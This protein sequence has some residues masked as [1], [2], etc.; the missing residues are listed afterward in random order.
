[1]SNV[2]TYTYGA[3]STGNPQLAN[4]LLTITSPNAQPGGPDAGNDTVNVYD[5]SGRV[6]SQTDP[7]GFQTTF[8][9][10]VNAA[11]GDCMNPATGTGFVTVS[12]PDGNTTVYSYQQGTL[13]AT[14]KFTGTTLTSRDRS[15]SPTRPAGTLLDTTSTDGNGNTTTDTY[16]A[17]G[18]PTQENAPAA[19]GTATTTTGY[20]T[21]AAATANQANCTSTADATAACQADSP[22]APVAPGGMI[23]PPSSAPPVG[24]TYTLYDTD[25]NELYSTTGVYQP[26]AS[27]AAYSR[28]TYQL[29]KGNSVT[30]NGT[31]ISCTA[32]PPSQSLPCATINAD[33]VVTQLAYDSAGDLTST[34]TPDGNGTEVATT[35]YAYDGDG[36]QTSAVSP[37]GNLS[38]ANT[39][40]Y[41]TVTAY[42]ADA[43]KTSVTQGGGTGHTVTAR[44]TSYGYD[45]DGN[46]TTEQ[47][48]RGYTTTTTFNADDKA[49]LV[50]DPD[51]NATLTCYD[52]DGNTA[53][54]VPPAGVAANS[55]TPS[56][57]PTSYPSGYGARLASDATTYTFDGAGRKTQ[58]TTPA[59][60]GQ[61]GSETTTYTY[62]GDGNLLTTTAPPTLNGGSSQVTSTRTLPQGSSPRRQPGTAPFGRNGQLLLRPERRQDLR[63]VRRRQHLRHRIV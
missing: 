36:E 9:Y 2:T 45:A 4:D 12:D 58:T 47:D 40:N 34:S 16:N 49:T 53:Q 6:T 22:P 59:P 54:T 33:G 42:N 43:E 17:A 7:M 29:F 23:T 39:G 32:T 46:Q 35:T 48:A 37:D 61:T 18:N 1:M 38:G 5:S 41:T 28:T 10:C 51:G 11:A 3:G 62:D 55:L 15:S 27:S 60:A 20:A 14:S 19:T 8:N 31:A 63:G 50:T 30:L 25:G 57:C 26:G 56:S 13:A 52:G 21:A 44:V 24:A